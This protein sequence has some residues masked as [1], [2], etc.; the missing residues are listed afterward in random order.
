[1]ISLLKYYL[2][3][4]IIVIGIISIILLALSLI[5]FQEGFMHGIGETAHIINNPINTI[6][7][8]SI[9]LSIIIPVFEFSF[10]MRKVGIDEFY[11][12]PITRKKLFLTK[13]IIGFLE[14]LLP[15]ISLWLF[16]LIRIL[17]SRHMFNLQY[18]FIYLIV[19]IPLIFIIY[20]I[21]TFVYSKCNT[22]YDGLICIFLASMLTFA[23]GEIVDN[24]FSNIDV[25][26][27]NSWICPGTN[28]F[29]IFSPINFV[30]SKLSVLMNQYSPSDFRKSE[31]VSL[32]VYLIF[33]VI[34]F[35]LLVL[36]ADKEK[37]E[38]SMDISN[39]WFSYKTLI[40]IYILYFSSDIDFE[41]I[42]V[43]LIVI[44]GYIAYAIYRRNFKIKLCDIITMIV[45]IVL[46]IIIGNIG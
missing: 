4:R 40:P 9:I 10:K 11:K 1:M 34:C 33:G 25:C 13:Y 46:G 41:L 7:T 3:K 16:M 38:N 12:F 6:G 44:L 43:L 28:D 17:C 22:I 20:S 18:Y 5:I 42:Y 39:S 15:I 14:V 2:K 19:L 35:I 31:I 21:I 30:S 29:F 8:I 24:F 26:M 45:C 23:L 32:I 37:A 36:L 27:N